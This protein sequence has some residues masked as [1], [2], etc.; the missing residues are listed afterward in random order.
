MEHKV[1]VHDLDP[2]LIQFTDSIGVRWYG[3]AYVTGFICA[4]FFMKWFSD[5]KISP[6]T[7]EQVSD[8]LTT[9]I[10]GVLLGGRLGYAL[11]YSPSLF[12]DFRPDF[13]F[14][15]VLAVWEG[16]M[17]SHGGFIGVWLACAY[18]SWR[19]K[20]EFPHLGD[21]TVVGAMIGIFLGRLAN[22]ANGEL[23]GRVCDASYIFAVK[24][25]QDIFRWVGYEPENL[26]KLKDTVATLGISPSDWNLWLSNIPRYRSKFYSV[27][28]EIIEQVQNHNEQVTEAVG[29]ALEPRH[30]SQLYAALTEG[31][32]PLIITLWLWRKPRK[33]GI[34]GS[35]FIIIYGLGRI[36][37]E[38]FRLPDAHISD[39]SQ[40]PLGISRGQ[41]ISLWMLIVGFGFLIWSIKRKS[42]PLGGWAQKS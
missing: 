32:I 18:F 33:P 38:Q 15:G 29:K 22:F 30:P 17:A 27:A 16:G 9:L 39:L 4:F 40:Q 35:I 7:V 34:I 19:H 42:K 25:P 8:F 3:L 11:F 37:N 26:P 1:W 23:M 2:F 12:T 28:N 5:K 6:M 41:F 14:W 31:L 36:F 10:L 20:I 24:F 21:L 13:P